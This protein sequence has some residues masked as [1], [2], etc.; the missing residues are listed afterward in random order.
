MQMPYEH[1]KHMDEIKSDQRDKAA[2]FSNDC[3]Y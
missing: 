3:H 2:A 1:I